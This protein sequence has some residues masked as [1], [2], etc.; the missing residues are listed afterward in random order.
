MKTSP[1]QIQDGGGGVWP[2][3]IKCSPS[4]K[5]DRKVPGTCASMEI[6]LCGSGNCPRVWLCS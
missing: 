6:D 4:G 1:F 5:Q 2:Q 3:G